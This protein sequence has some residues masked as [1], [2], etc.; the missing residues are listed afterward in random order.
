MKYFIACAFLLLTI[1]KQ[2]VCQNEGFVDLVDGRIHY[3]WQGEGPLVLIINGGPGFNCEGF[4][5][6]AG[7]I[8]EMG[9]RTVI[10]DQRGTGLSTHA[11]KESITLD[12][13]IEDLE[14]LREHLEVK[15]WTILGH[16]FGGMLAAYYCTKYPDHVEGVVFSSSGGINLDLFSGSGVR[17]K[18]SEHQ[19]AR[20]DELNSAIQNGDTTYLTRLE[21]A[22]IMAHAYI[23]DTSYLD[24]VSVRLTQGDLELNSQIWQNMRTIN[25]DCTQSLKS[26][27]APVLILQGDQDVLDVSVAKHA[28]KTL[29]NSRLVMLNHCAHYGWLDNSE[30]YYGEIQRLLNEL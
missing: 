15:S 25:F 18:L 10:Y 9:Y 4:M 26:F 28:H 16:S 27:K 7:D 21:R 3:Y 6:L 23:V 14:H 13:M 2:A 11:G 24:V 20:M 30:Q 8:S 22:R 17:S 12:H 1:T 29:P 19:N 5:T